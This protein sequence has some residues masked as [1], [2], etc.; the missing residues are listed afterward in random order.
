MP[1]S[2]FS[3][4]TP[5]SLQGLR[6]NARRKDV[7][8]LHRKVASQ[9]SVARCR[10]PAL[11]IPDY[12]AALTSPTSHHVYIGS[13]RTYLAKKLDYSIN[14][15]FRLFGGSDEGEPDYSASSSSI[16]RGSSIRRNALVY[17]AKPC[18]LQ[19]FTY[20]CVFYSVFYRF[21]DVFQSVS[22]L[23]RFFKV[24]QH[25]VRGVQSVLLISSSVKCVAMIFK[26]LQVCR[27]NMYLHP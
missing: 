13:I 5:P 9:G 14:G 23:V 20:F 12:S 16:R 3:P 10:N 4:Q 19:V 27:S 17:S 26:L 7:A 1:V 21:F 25:S 18:F 11:P 24:V 8:R 6:R 22:R 15:T 2:R